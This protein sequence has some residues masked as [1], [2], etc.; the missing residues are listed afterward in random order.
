M[1][2]FMQEHLEKVIKEKPSL[3]RYP[4]RISQYLFKTVKLLI[5]KYESDA[6]N[7]W[8]NKEADEILKNLKEFSGIGEKKSALGVMLLIRDFGIKIKNKKSINIAY[9]IHIRRVFLRT[10]L[11]KKDNINL[12][13]NSAK[14]INPNFPGELTAPIW[15]IGRKWC[16]PS[17][18]TCNECPLFAN[19]PK[20]I[21]LGKDIKA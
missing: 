14:H 20:Y 18:P 16:R 7:I 19:C 8:R 5:E 1:S 2:E 10:G 4:K 9:D 11:A 6:T 13:I 21:N 3:H 12:V 15:N 17:T